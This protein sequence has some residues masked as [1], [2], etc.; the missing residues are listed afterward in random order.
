[1]PSRGMTRGRTAQSDAT[2]PLDQPKRD[3]VLVGPVLPLQPAA[4]SGRIGHSL[5]VTANLALAYSALGAEPAWRE[6]VDKE[7]GKPLSGEA[8][9]PVGKTADDLAV[10]A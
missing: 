8:L 7:N 10:W 6:A 2:A 5:T 4:R 3:A 1:M 9:G